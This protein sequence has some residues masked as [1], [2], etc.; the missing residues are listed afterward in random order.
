MPWKMTSVGLLVALS[1]AGCSSKPDAEPVSQAPDTTVSDGRC[2]AAG[3]QFAIGQQAS[4]ALL[5][6]AKSKA[7]A[8][9]AR[10]VGPNEMVTL[11]YR[12][13]RVNLNTDAAGKVMRVSCG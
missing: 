7:G 10:F 2:D 8:Q 6:Q 5:A 4:A 11:E 13:T 1:L 3:G 12:S 9:E